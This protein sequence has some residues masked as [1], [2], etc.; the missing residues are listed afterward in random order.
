MDDIYLDN[1]Y[2]AEYTVTRK[3][4]NTG[5]DEAA[6]GLT[7]LTAR[8]SATDGGAAIGALTGSA[9]ERGT[10]GIYYKIFD[11]DALRT[12]LA[13]LYVGVRVWIIFGDGT[14]VLVSNP[15]T[16]RATRRAA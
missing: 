2:E 5:A 7:G 14:N 16:V 1:D 12:A 11:G 9:S 6:T 13:T 4:A 10:L 15:V 3:N 8:I